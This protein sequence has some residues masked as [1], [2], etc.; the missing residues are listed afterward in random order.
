METGVQLPTVSQATVQITD[1]PCWAK[2]SMD[3]CDRKIQWT[4]EAF[5]NKPTNLK[6]LEAAA[7][8]LSEMQHMIS[9][10]IKIYLILFI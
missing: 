6:H 7:D 9:I 4:I 2:V 3:L 10:I 5:K 1:S 8:V